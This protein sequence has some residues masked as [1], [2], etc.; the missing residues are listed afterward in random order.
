MV[1]FGRRRNIYQ[2]TKLTSKS[3]TLMY[4][5]FDTYPYFYLNSLNHQVGNLLT[6]NE[7][8]STCT[9]WPLSASGRTDH[10]LVHI[11]KLVTK[12]TEVITSGTTAGKTA[13]VSSEYLFSHIFQASP[14]KLYVICNLM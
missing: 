5:P 10:P 3:T 2:F 4:F 1:V 9:I 12:R 8:G 6:A 14:R 11:F 13:Q 7:A